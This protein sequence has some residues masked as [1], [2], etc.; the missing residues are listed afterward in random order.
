MKDGLGR[1]DAHLARLLKQQDDLGAR[2]ARARN[3]R[4]DQAL[5]KLREAGAGRL[6]PEALEKLIENIRGA[7]QVQ[8][9]APIDEADTKQDYLKV[10]VRLSRN[11]SEQKQGALRTAGL[12]WNGK[13]GRYIGRV[14]KA[15]LTKLIAQF[16]S[17]VE[18]EGAEEPPP[19]D[20]GS[21]SSAATS[22]V[23][24]SVDA[25]SMAAELAGEPVPEAAL[26]AD[27]TLPVDLFTAAPAA[28]DPAA[29][30]ELSPTSATVAP[31][32]GLQPPLQARWR[33][34]PLPRP[35]KI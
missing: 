4:E 18:V 30:A 25:P 2:I 32:E 14:S 10:K 34:L 9:T 23:L 8:A 15:T 17:R 16:G 1:A 5:A 12:V 19:P 20:G 28:E 24:P 31:R 27:Q 33:P 29:A 22:A 35:T 6:Q 7:G 11:A 21:P 26:E 3:E 13:Q